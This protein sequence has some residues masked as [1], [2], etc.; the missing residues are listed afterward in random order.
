MFDDLFD[1]STYSTSLK[2]DDI[3]IIGMCGRFALSD[4]KNEFWNSLIEGKN[5]I[6]NYPVSRSSDTEKFLLNGSVV[7]KAGYLERIDLFDYRFF[8]IS[9][10]EAD[11]TDP[12]QRI[13]METVYNAFC[14]A[15]ISPNNLRGSK[16][17]VY[18]AHS[19][20]LNPRYYEF[21]RENYPDEFEDI[22]VAGNLASVMSGRISYY[23]DLQGPAV[24]VDTACSSALVA[25]DSA[26]N[27]LNDRKID[28]AVVGGVKINILPI[29]RGL[30]DDI[31]IRS[32]NDRIRAFD[33]NADGISS[34][35]G[36]GAIILKRYSDAKNDGDRIYAVIK[37]CA[38]NN[39]G[40]S[41][42][43]TAPNSFAQEE[44]ICEAWEKAKIDPEK[45]VYIETHGTGTNLGDPVEAVALTKAFKRYTD[46]HSFCGIGSVKTGYGHLDNISGLISLIK[47]ALIVYNRVIPPSI[48]F[49]RPNAKI[50]F[51]D[52][53]LYVNDML[54]KIDQDEYYCGVSSFG[55]SG[56]NAHIVIGPAENDNAVIATAT[57]TEQNFAGERCWVTK[58]N[59]NVLLGHKIVTT[60]DTVMYS[61]VYSNRTHWILNE[62]K[63]KGEYVLPGTALIE[64]M[65]TALN[66]S[67][68][69]EMNNICLKDVFFMEAVRTK[70]G[71]ECDVITSIVVQ[72]GNKSISIGSMKN[73][74]WRRHAI[75]VACESE[76]K[77]DKK[78]VKH[79]L[80]G[81]VSC[82]EERSIDVEIGEH[83][84]QIQ[85]KLYKLSDNEY[86]AEF[87]VPRRFMLE[88]SKS[89]L[90]A[91]AMD[92][93]INAINAVL[94]NGTYIP[95]NIGKMCIYGSLPRRFSVYIDI[96]SV[97][98]EVIKMNC[99]L[100]DEQGILFAEL[101]DYIVKH[102][103]GQVKNKNSDN[104]LCAV[105]WKEVSD[106]IARSQ[107]ESKK[108]I[109]V[110]SDEDK[111]LK[112]T[113]MQISDNIITLTVDE[114]IE[115]N[116]FDSYCS[117]SE[118]IHIL[119]IADACKKTE[120]S[121]ATETISFLEK[122]YVL[123]AAIAKTQLPNVKLTVVTHNAFSVSGNETNIVPVGRALTAMAQVL[124]QE[125]TD[126]ELCC[127]DIDAGLVDCVKD[128]ILHN[129]YDACLCA[130]RN[131]RIYTPII[132]SIRT[133]NT[134]DRKRGY[135]GIYL[136]AGNGD[137]ARAIAEHMVEQG[138]DKVV[139][140]GR[141][142]KGIELDERIQEMKCD[143]T[144]RQQ[145]ENT[146]STIREKI[147]K[148]K[149]FVHCAAVVDNNLIIHKTLQ[150]FREVISPKIIG[151][152]TIIDCLKEDNLEW[153]V[154]FSS[155]SSIVGGI[156]QFDYSAANAYEDAFA[157]EQRRLGNN[158]IAINWAAWREIGIAQRMGVDDDNNT[159]Y[160][161]GTTE[162]LEI[163]D[164]LIGLNETGHIVG[165]INNKVFDST[166]LMFDRHRHASVSIRS[167]KNNLSNGYVEDT[168]E[169]IEAVVTSVWSEILGNTNIGRDE[170]FSKLGGDSIMAIRLM[171]KLRDYYPD[172]IDITMI[173][174]YPSIAL[175]TEAL[176]KK[177]IQMEERKFEKKITKVNSLDEI[178]NALAKGEISVADIT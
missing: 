55:L 138:A 153:S 108:W 93:A 129:H 162:A 41:V 140:L 7:C 92:R 173:F 34:G 165:I 142:I 60:G 63:V 132:D 95:F 11:M 144:D 158:V 114:V 3:A 118:C 161:L 24:V 152:E 15:G 167:Y 25:V 22:S 130:V 105:V 177:R 150:N 35:E 155:V 168:A 119:D 109:I 159:F 101:F 84:N 94:G 110:L 43:L 120:Y 2:D 100:Y 96:L 172:D 48:W 29:R 14:D 74:I 174:T 16:T 143:I 128:L 70:E 4:N 69:G 33:N 18:T 42:G 163:F 82:C 26:C 135:K 76:D 61:T 164:K 59:K 10:Q 38:V 136:L 32:K 30:D 68:G 85:R 66:E 64:M 106:T 107:K 62:H 52:S 27:A 71:E 178:L 112:N 123:Y 90:W 160:S 141:H 149:G 78:I 157:E 147:G 117:N 131:G 20:E 31:G 124:K 104:K 87:E 175:M 57:I 91:P 17:G 12:N 81:A 50:G 5:C 37:G 1:F 113:I 133:S 125:C 103:N 46:R 127:V 89:K 77:L 116:S 88:V 28:L 99:Q 166:S 80:D 126:I 154:L 121:Y 49:E 156:G 148:V 146:I 44:V 47:T 6:C 79:S 23:F 115:Q 65:I 13:Y 58:K 139:M 122:R 86:L 171:N 176:V 137:L 21:I 39:D 169:D 56:T 53:S 97:N 75:A 19:S 98:D 170:T 145:V 36:A 151:T 45:I 111:D 73:G 51:T 54:R 83:W 8:G 67:S 102:I 134:K 72:N 40:K 9:K